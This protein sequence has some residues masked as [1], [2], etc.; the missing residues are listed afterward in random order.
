MADRTT[1]TFVFSREA[2]TGASSVA[3]Q[4]WTPWDYST[5]EWDAI[6]YAG[7]EPHLFDG[8]VAA[9]WTLD[10]RGEERDLE[11]HP[12][13]E[14]FGDYDAGGAGLTLIPGGYPQG[15]PPSLADLVRER[16][17]T[18]KVA[19]DRT[20]S[21]LDAVKGG[22]TIWLRLSGGE[23]VGGRVAQITER[24]VVLKK[25]WSWQT[26]APKSK[27]RA[28]KFVEIAAARKPD[29]RESVPGPEFGGWMEETNDLAVVPQL[30][31]ALCP[32]CINAVRPPWRSGPCWRCRAGQG[33]EIP[34]SFY[35][36]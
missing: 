6:Y 33:R 29:R 13:D 25:P 3:I 30:H 28:I 2:E 36:L 12:E 34:D 24:S 19:W 4:L 17:A 23:A 1:G 21:V 32:N 8:C 10:E 14:N 31:T 5:L 26:G 27:T 16:E 11:V 9:G 20:A 7:A 22:D 15:T 35:A 18:K